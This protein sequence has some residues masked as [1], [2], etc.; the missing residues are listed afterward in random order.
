MDIIRNLMIAIP[1][2]AETAELDM[3]VLAG[4]VFDRLLSL[5]GDDIW[6]IKIWIAHLLRLCKKHDIMLRVLE[7]TP[8]HDW[9]QSQLFPSINSIAKIGANLKYVKDL[10]IEHIE[11]YG[12]SVLYVPDEWGPTTEN[13]L[14]QV[15][16]LLREHKLTQVD[17][18]FMHGH[19][20]FQIPAHLNLPHHNAEE[21]LKIVKEHIFIGHDHKF[22]QWQRITAQGSFDCLGHGQEEPK[23]HVRWTK[24]AN[25]DTECVF[26]Q[27]KN[28]KR[29]VTAR[30]LG[31]DLDETMKEVGKVV[32]GIPDG[33]FVR[34]EGDTKNPIFSNMMLL[35]RQWPL[36][37]FT[38]LVKDTGP[39]LVEIIDH[40]DVYVPITITKDNLS[41]LLM[42]RLVMANLSNQLLMAART[43]LKG[44]L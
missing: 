13:T 35:V 25:G 28:A 9:K 11:R 41:D 3:I 1:D 40:T 24:H 34:V 39:Q 14:S 18:A 44:A 31:M 38:K 7:G 29:Y 8:S 37:T 6:E 20:A 15:H 36:M 17:Y 5:S 33:S 10:S 30:C 23:G 12:I 42:D 22:A 16:A 4:D 32:A 27:T 19:F 21:Y 43:I 2:N 26:V